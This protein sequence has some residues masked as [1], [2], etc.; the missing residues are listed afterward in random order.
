MD[1]SAERTKVE[2]REWGA[3]PFAVAERAGK[4]VLLSLSARWCVGC[5]EMDR[6][7]YDEPRIA[8][9]CSDGFVPVRVDADRQ[10]RVRERYAMGGFPS[11]VFLT[12]DG[13]V[14]TGAGYLGQDGMRQVLDRVRR[15]WD[16][17][18]AAAGTVP[19]ALA[20]DPT[21]S[22]DLS[23]DIVER[24][25]GRLRDLSDERAGGWGESQKFP[26]PGAIE[27]ALKHDRETALRSL[28][29]VSAN[30]L[31][32][33]DGG[34]FRVA[35]NRDWSGLHHEKITDVNAALVRAFANAYLYTGREE[36]RTPAAETVEYLTTTL[37]VADPPG[38][39]R[40]AFAGSQAGDET[41]YYRLGATERADADPPA[42]DETVFADRTA[43]A[44]DA[45]LTYH[46]YTDDD[47]ARQFAERALD[48][49]RTSLVEDGETVHF[50]A[51]GADG[52]TAPTGLL[53]DQAAVLGALTTAAQVLGADTVAEAEAVAD[54]TID[55][56]HDE[57][58][59]RDGPADGPALL[60]RPLRPLDDNV[61][62]A[63]ALLDLAAMTGD[64]RYRGVARESAAA[65]AGAA[66]RFGPQIASYGSVVSRLLE[67]Q[68]TVAVAAP[69]G[70]DLH[71]AALRVADHDVVVLPD[72]DG[73]RFESG[74]AY[75]V[76]GEEVAPP[77]AT[78]Q[79][80]SERVAELL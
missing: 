26:L 2:F 22:G 46:A 17:K 49:L 19:R 27:F 62:M 43:L 63:D 64:D 45:L 77:A 28:S 18:G 51:A 74:H 54:W 60:S 3:E 57:G 25:T 56:L 44:V 52:E 55:H 29:A 15:S 20:G 73:E 23:A 80:L 42:V 36:F 13:E 53:A 78:P 32:D 66:D 34:F 41:G 7:T 48:Y 31:D 39:G 21:P 61:A 71:R 68:L 69:A 11:T 24:L 70:S 72:A 47:R 40:G 1:E 59:F 76:R 6:E 50:R 30:L 12:P 14:L 65:F 16:E 79:E 4:P 37:W 33:V 5:H 67:P 75:V 35:E 10:P 38:G 8:A 9:N 58:S